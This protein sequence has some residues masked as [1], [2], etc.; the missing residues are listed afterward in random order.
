MSIDLFQFLPFL[1]V[2]ICALALIVSVP[3]G[4]AISVVGTKICA[5]TAG[6]KKY[7][8]TIGKNN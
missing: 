1:D 5:I 4:I 2:L 3:I 6:I 7:K 8:S